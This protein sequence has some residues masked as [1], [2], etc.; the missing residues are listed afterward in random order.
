MQIDFNKYQHL[1]TDCLLK[2]T[3]EFIYTHQI[4]LHPDISLPKN[5]TNDIPLTPEFCR[6]DPSIEEV[7]A[8]NQCR[9]YLKAYH[10]SDLVTASGKQLS[11]HA[12]EG[13]L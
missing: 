7:T 11:Y 2:S 5:T 8:L 12:W 3:W 13:S 4:T 6:L 1:A 9:L 10:I